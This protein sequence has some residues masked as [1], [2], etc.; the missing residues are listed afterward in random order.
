MKDEPRH[1]EEFVLENA[2]SSNSYGRPDYEG[3]SE[4]AARND[5]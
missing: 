5:R 1:L 2:K 3:V 4:A